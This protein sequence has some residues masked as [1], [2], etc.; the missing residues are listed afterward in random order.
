M[1]TNL[2]KQARK[3]LFE[4]GQNSDNN[5]LDNRFTFVYPQQVFKNKAQ[6]VVY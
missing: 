3:P 1:T 4:K 6:T 2:N 5:N